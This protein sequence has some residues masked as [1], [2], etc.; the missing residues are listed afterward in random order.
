MNSRISN[1]IDK[2]PP[3]VSGNG[4]HRQTFKVCMILLEGFNLST[5]EAREYLEYYNRQCSPPWNSRE[6]DHK[7]NSAA[8]RVNPAKAGRLNHKKR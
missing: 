6:L 5:S 4:G 3:A 7:I 8:K 1:Y 2:I